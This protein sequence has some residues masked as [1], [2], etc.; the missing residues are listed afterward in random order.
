MSP[1][2]ADDRQAA[3]NRLAER[4]VD[5]RF[6]NHTVLPLLEQIAEHASI[7]LEP[8]DLMHEACLRLPVPPAESSTPPVAAPCCRRR[9]CRLPAA[10]IAPAAVNRHVPSSNINCSRRRHRWPCAIRSEP[11]LAP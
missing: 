11:A 2:P 5:E 3:A 7:T 10:P 4:A 6:W 9:C 8:A 1:D